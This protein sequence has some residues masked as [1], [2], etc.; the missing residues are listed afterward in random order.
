VGSAWRGAF[1]H[2]LKRTV[3]ITQERRCE[4]CLLYRS[5]SYPY[6][7]ETPVPPGSALM[8]RYVTAP[9]PFVLRCVERSGVLQEGDRVE[10]GLVTV[11]HGDHYLP[12]MIHALDQAGQ[13]GIGRDRVPLELCEVLQDEFPGDGAA[14]IVYRP[15]ETL[16]RRGP[17]PP[18]LPPV[19]ASVHLTI[20]T[21]LRQR[22]DEHYLTPA[23]FRARDLFANLLRRVSSLAYF[24]TGREILADYRALLDAVTDERLI[25]KDLRWQEWTRYSSRQQQRMQMGGLLGTLTLNMEGIE[26][27]WPYLYLGQWLHAG[28]GTSMGLGRY[29]LS[30]SLPYQ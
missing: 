25:D 7:F 19:P 15:G 1:G 4:R 16:N 9:H 20:E 27:L 12:Y 5:C 23:S 2:A 29:V 26:G 11:G 17:Q 21:P 3:C 6:V 28:K 14:G 10:L 8:G 24:H 22:R 13:R 30:A 18:P